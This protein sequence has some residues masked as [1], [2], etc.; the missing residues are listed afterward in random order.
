MVAAFALP[1]PKLMMVMPF[2]EA[3]GID[4]RD[5]VSPTF[6]LAQE[7]HGRAVVAKFMIMYF[8]LWPTS[9]E[10]KN[11]Y[12]VVFVPDVYLLINGQRRQRWTA[13]YD[14]DHYRKGLDEVRIAYV[15]ESPKI[16]ESTK[17]LG[18]ALAVYQEKKARSR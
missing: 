16:R 14:I 5:V 6:V 18:A 3:L 1:M 11:E 13:D 7:Y 8:T 9:I 2:A 15:L 10:I 4:R 12:D 17:I